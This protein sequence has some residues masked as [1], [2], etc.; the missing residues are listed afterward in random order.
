MSHRQ[1]SSAAVASPDLKPWLRL[2]DIVFVALAI[3]L[4]LVVYFAFAATIGSE[5]SGSRAR[6]A[7]YNRQVDG[8]REGHLYL[9]KPAPALLFQLKNPYDPVAN[10]PARGLMYSPTCNHDLTFYH[11]RLYLYFSVVPAV[12]LFLPFRVLTGA[13]L[14]QQYACAVFA[15]LAFLTLAGVLVLAWRR[16]FRAVSPRWLALCVLGLGLAP[17]TPVVLQRPDVYEVPVCCEYFFVAVAILSLWRL[18]HGARVSGWWSALLSLCIGC[19]IG[20]RPSDLP[21]GFLL[22]VPVVLAWRQGRRGTPGAPS[23]WR[24]V[25]A[26]VAPITVVGLA[27][28]WYNYARFGSPAEF[29]L[30][31]QLNR[32]PRGLA[33]FGLNHVPYN[34]WMYLVH[35]PG[36]SWHFPFAGPWRSGW[37][38]PASFA[39]VEHPVGLLAGVP[40]VVFAAFVAWSWRRLADGLRLFVLAVGWIG[41]SNAALLLMF[42]GSVARYELSFAPEFVLLACLGVLC[43]EARLAVRPSAWG[44]ALRAGWIASVVFSVVYGVLF[45]VRVRG[46]DYAV[47]GTSLL[48]QHDNRGTLRKYAQALACDPD[49]AEVRRIKGVVEL[50]TGDVRTAETDFR[51]LLQQVPHD[52]VALNA[53]GVI[54]AK[55]DPAAAIG[56][57]ERSIHADSHL[58]NAHYNLAAMIAGVPARRDEALRECRAALRLNPNYAEARQLLD[59]LQ[60]NTTGPTSSGGGGPM[61]PEA[62]GTRASVEAL[63]E[64]AGTAVERGRYGDAVRAYER[65]L[66]VAPNDAQA[67]GNLGALLCR[68]PAKRQQ[69]I[70]HLRRAIQL[71]PNFAEAHNNLAYALAADPRERA[72]AIKEYQAAL[73]I[74]PDYPEARANLQRLLATPPVPRH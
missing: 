67:E 50:N 43:L 68:D 36:W 33:S 15:S 21:L 71:D 59:R 45:A 72:E 14:S 40:M 46:S 16:Y 20:A 3:I 34:A 47:E 2:R 74:R 52:A 51:I 17:L 19:A 11:G 5:T 57:F 26:A 28:L 32:D 73:A 65:I 35:F 61:M 30:R 23:M 42:F 29:G 48:L 24:V 44:L 13:Y 54:V 22:L 66:V 39:S 12:V 6:D 1:S 38:K 37:A 18:A 49:L 53:M 69:A 8:F 9:D 62:G 70:Q 56:Y 4:S 7:Y 58:P 41:I 10:G 25:G 64:I 27:L 55:T 60:K 31:Y 63:R